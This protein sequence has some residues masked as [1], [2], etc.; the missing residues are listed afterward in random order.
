MNYVI[1]IKNLRNSKPAAPNDIRVD[2]ANKVL[3]NQFYMADESMRDE[4]CDLYQVW[5]DK[6]VESK[7]PEVMTELRRLWKIWK[8]Y[9]TLNLYCWCAPK[10]CHAQTIRDFLLKFPP[11]Q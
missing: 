11:K 3:G 10:R 8:E 6:K 4:V 5:F 7:D 2:R 9:G 1:N